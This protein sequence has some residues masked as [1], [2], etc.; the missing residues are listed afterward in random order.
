MLSTKWLRCAKPMFNFVSSQVTKQKQEILEMVDTSIREN[1][2]AFC[3]TSTLKNPQSDCVT[4]C[5]W[6]ERISTVSMSYDMAFSGC[7]IFEKRFVGF[8]KDD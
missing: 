1:T 7:C 8:I 2:K 4:V 6:V 5:Y 3:I